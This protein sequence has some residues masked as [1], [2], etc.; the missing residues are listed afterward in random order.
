VVK[1][2]R[3]PSGLH[4][5]VVPVDSVRKFSVVSVT[6]PTSPVTRFSRPSIFVVI[7]IVIEVETL[8]AKFPVKA[9]ITFRFVR[10]K[11]RLP[12][13]RISGMLR[14]RTPMRMKRPISTGVNRSSFVPGTSGGP[15]KGA[16]RHWLDA[17]DIRDTQAYVH[18]H[19]RD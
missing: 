14:L 5:E 8:A 19:S 4:R 11:C 3:E 7:V 15:L 6:T 17:R 9:M 12:V 13:K 2:A 1:V 18:R 10:V 16:P